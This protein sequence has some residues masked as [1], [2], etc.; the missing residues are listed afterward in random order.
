M[1]RAYRTRLMHIYATDPT[2]VAFCIS[3]GIIT[4]SFIRLLSL[5]HQ[6]A[7]LSVL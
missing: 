7:A 5:V 1:Q 2:G 6:E 3:P 4:R